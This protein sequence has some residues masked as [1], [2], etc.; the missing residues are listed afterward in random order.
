MAVVT[1]TTRGQA[2]FRKE[3]FQ[4]VGIKPGDQFEIDYLP[5]GEFKGRAVRR[6]GTITELSGFL[7]GK[8]NGAV[9]TIEEINEAIEQ[10][11]AE[12]GM[13]GLNL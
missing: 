4:H 10:A 12:A 1:T 11:G 2:T 9:L 5:N 7:A 8:T 13:A 6:K 3:F